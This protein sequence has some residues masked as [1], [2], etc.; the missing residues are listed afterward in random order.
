MIP[1]ITKS[2][3]IYS[4]QCFQVYGSLTK[5]IIIAKLKEKEPLIFFAVLQKLPLICLAWNKLIQIKINQEAANINTMKTNILAPLA[6]IILSI[7]LILIN[8]CT[9]DTE[10]ISD[11]GN[12]NNCD[13]TNVTYSV[14][15]KG[16]LENNACLSC[17]SGTAVDGGN[18]VLDNYSGIS[19]YAANGKLYGA[20]NHESGY[21][22][23]PKGGD[24]LSDCNLR[25]IKIWIDDGFQNN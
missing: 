7:F 11:L 4:W 17:H 16:I 8:S 3:E 12:S 22:A 23:M 2:S 20:L 15:I 18:V 25:K 10:S 14:S 5:G 1:F 6:T 9:H 13:T 19:Q 21:P 24:K